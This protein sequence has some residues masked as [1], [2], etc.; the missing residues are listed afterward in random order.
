[1]IIYWKLVKIDFIS[2]DL[3][4]LKSCIWTEFEFNKII[5]LW[6]NGNGKMLQTSLKIVVR[7]QIYEWSFC[8]DEEKEDIAYLF[9]VNC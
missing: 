8:H 4:E 2:W 3:I 6:A 7:G 5:K 1:M 9:F